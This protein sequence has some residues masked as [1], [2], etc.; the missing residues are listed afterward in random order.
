M[1]R[2]V[3]GNLEIRWENQAQWP[4]RPRYSLRF[5]DPNDFPSKSE[6][7]IYIVGDESLTSYLRQIGVPSGEALQLVRLIRRIQPI[8]HKHSV[9]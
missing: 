6:P 8:Y 3:A 9:A 4:A 2:I 5:R 1:L 7:D